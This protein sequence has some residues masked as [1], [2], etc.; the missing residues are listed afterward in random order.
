MCL[1]PQAKSEASLV[2]ACSFQR[3]TVYVQHVGF[4]RTK[5]AFW[6]GFFP[7]ILHIHDIQ[8][9]NQKCL[10]L[11]IFTVK[12]SR[13]SMFN[14]NDGAEKCFVHKGRSTFNANGEASTLLIW[15]L[16]PCS[17]DI[18]LLKASSSL[19]KGLPH[20]RFLLTLFPY[21]DEHIHTH[22]VK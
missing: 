11:C 8:S 14:G 18:L 1:T 2:L 13:P 16:S 9:W 3:M 20:C 10:Y 17:V 6:P 12:L 22:Y 4:W 7:L 19:S 5:E 21:R 15:Q